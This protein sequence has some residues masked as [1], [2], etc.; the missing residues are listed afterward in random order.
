[1]SCLDDPRLSRAIFSVALIVGAVMSSHR[2]P[3]EVRDLRQLRGGEHR[4]E[5]A[6]GRP[7]R[8]RGD[9]AGLSRQADHGVEKICRLVAGADAQ[10]GVSLESAAAHT[11][12]FAD[13]M[14]L[15]QRVGCY[16][17]GHP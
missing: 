9:I 6:G 12:S 8:G 17:D 16:I 13:A 11:L 15:D 3:S 2:G 7:L 10:P 14:V 1:M 4:A 5:A